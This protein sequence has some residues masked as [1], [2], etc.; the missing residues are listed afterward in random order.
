VKPKTVNISGEPIFSM[1]HK[2]NYKTLFKYKN[3]RVTDNC[4]IMVENIL[5]PGAYKSDTLAIDY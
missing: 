2:M 4:K 1:T 3:R 5:R